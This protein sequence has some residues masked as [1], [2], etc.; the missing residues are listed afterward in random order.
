MDRR[1]DDA[2]GVDLAESGSKWSNGVVPSVRAIRRAC[3]RLASTTP[4]SSTSGKFGQD[5]GVVLAQVPDAD[6]RHP[7]A[8]HFYPR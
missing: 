3:S 1:G 5:A 4:T 8:C 2:D 7:Q 6:H